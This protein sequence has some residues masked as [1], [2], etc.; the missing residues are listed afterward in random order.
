MSKQTTKEQVVNLSDYANYAWRT[1]ALETIE[2]RALPDIFDGM[3][4]VG[5]RVLYEMARM[6]LT[7]G[8]DPVKTARVVG[9]TMG[10]LHPHGDASIGSAIATLV[11]SAIPPI[12]GIG[13]WGDRDDNPAAPRYCFS[14]DTRVMTEVGLLTFDQLKT[15]VPGWQETKVATDFP[16]NLRVDSLKTKKTTS[17]FVNSGVQDTVVVTSDNGRKVTCT[18]NEPFLVITP[19]GF[20]W[21]D[22]EHL[23]KD[24]WVC[25]KR[26]SDVAD[27]IKSGSVFNGV[28]LSRSLAYTLGYLV[29][30]GYINNGQNTVGFNQVRDDTFKHFV[31]HWVKC[32]PSEFPYTVSALQPRSYGK[33]EYNQFHCA[34][35]PA[36]QWFDNLGLRSGD[37][38]DRRVPDC[39]WQMSKDEVACFLAALYE[40]DGT[41]S[42]DQHGTTG[43][44][45]VSVSRKLL[46]DVSLLIQS[47]FGIFTAKI[48]KNT[49]TAFA[50]YITD[51][52]S[53]NRYV[54]LIGAISKDKVKA[55]R[56]RGIVD[57]ERARNDVIP[58]ANALGFSS[59]YE[60]T[61]NAMFRQK[62]EA[63][64]FKS[65]AA[66][67]IYAR[68]YYFTRVK[69]VKKGPKVPVYD[70]TVPATSA[71]V[72]NGF[73]VHNTNCRLT[74]YGMMLVDKD[75]L[76][77]TPMC[78]NYDGKE[79][80]P[81]VLPALLP[82]LF[83]NGGSG[84]AVGITFDLPP[85]EAKGVLA[86]VR[87]ILS[88]DDVTPAIAA[89][90]TRVSYVNGSHQ[91][92]ESKLDKQGW[93]E[94][95]KTGKSTLKIQPKS[96]VLDS[97]TST[98]TV[99]G[100]PLPLKMT[101]LI[102][103]L[104]A[105]QRVKEVRNVGITKLG[106]DTLEIQLKPSRQLQTTAQE[107][108]QRMTTLVHP[109]LNCV[110]RKQVDVDAVESIQTRIRSDS[111]LD[112]LISWCKL[113]VSLEKRYLEYKSSQVKNSIDHT[114]LLI[115]ACLNRD[116]VLNA[117]KSKDPDSTLAKSLKISMEDAG[118]IL[119]M[120]VRRL[121]V[122]DE[123]K[124][125]ENLKKLQG[126]LKEISAWQK[127]P[128]DKIVADLKTIEAELNL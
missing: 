6:G 15:H 83:L 60:R 27:K 40:S 113:R 97:K 16:F 35:V 89:K 93:V 39:I 45:L 72:A 105:D 51:R 124:L 87:K 126:Q 67:S 110:Q 75:Y 65:R 48:G 21:K 127:R 68:N 24:D 23:T 103:S 41:I 18:P 50:L 82:N 91:V 9:N 114:N 1:Y 8:A 106:V 32:V 78:P 44:T 29:G 74:K 111:P 96:L 109:K 30:D 63:G 12:R 42:Y 55:C 36:R 80:E 122:L 19:N 33:K 4:P 10:K 86:L 98:M 70:L 77:V 123:A 56:T 14:G 102:E 59:G 120:Q 84:V 117:L 46:E 64:K 58:Y 62:C 128:Q 71:F 5:R 112:I 17:H 116:V 85:I 66:Q 22:A 119:D 99:P 53:I 104:E 7:P 61:P 25:L 20:R 121:S 90:L 13:N 115:K 107:L 26:D 73:I 76:A 79:K 31:A 94:F 28:T 69:S 38:Y 47:Y 37:S 34:S 54:N 57:Y 11:N 95:W 88:G 118:R 100:I 52:E 43:I 108:F 92:L 2:G 3:K 125:R 101:S 81:V 49:K